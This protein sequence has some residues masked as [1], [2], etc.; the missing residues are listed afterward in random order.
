MENPLSTNFTEMLVQLM[1][2][3]GKKVREIFQSKEIEQ[4]FRDVWKEA[5]CHEQ[6]CIKFFLRLNDYQREQLL[7]K[8][9]LPLT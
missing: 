7:E 6:T 2:L 1:E 5:K 3:D 8:F 4:L 9:K